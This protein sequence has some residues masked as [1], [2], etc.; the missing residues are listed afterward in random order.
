[1]NLI[2]PEHTPP[3]R[4]LKHFALVTATDL[5]IKRE[6]GS[7]QFEFDALVLSASRGVVSFPRR[8]V[9]PDINP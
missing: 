4:G 6:E 8:H 9:P 2:N 3:V 7:H 5:K 1:V